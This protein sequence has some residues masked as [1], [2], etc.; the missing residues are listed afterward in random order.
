[1]IS[2][3][4]VPNNRLTVT[5]CIVQT[6]EEADLRVGNLNKC[7]GINHADGT[8]VDGYAN[9]RAVMLDTQGP[10][11]RTGSFGNGV[12]EVELFTDQL[13][14]LHHFLCHGEDLT[15]IHYLRCLY[16]GRSR[17]QTTRACAT[18]RRRTSCGCPT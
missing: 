2:D 4:Y 17:L 11:I 1:L 3:R 18:T 15:L 10:E 16:A 9:M 5:F 8:K 7:F 12:K 14:R 13:V 6:Y